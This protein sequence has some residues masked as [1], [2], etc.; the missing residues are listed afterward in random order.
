MNEGLRKRFLKVTERFAKYRTWLRNAP[1]TSAFSNIANDLGLLAKC[2]SYRN[3]NIIAG[4][5]LK[6]VEWLRAQSWDFDSARDVISY[7][8]DIIESSE[9]D[10]LNVLP[11]S[12]TSVRIMN[13]HKAKGLEAPFVFLANTYGRNDNRK[14]HFHVDRSG[15]VTRGYLAITKPKGK[16]GHTRPIAT[17]A[18]WDQFQAEEK[19]FG[20]GEDD[21]LLY[22]A[23]TRA[24]CKLVVSIASGRGERSSFWK[25]LHDHL[26]SMS[27]LNVSNPINLNYQTSVAAPSMALAELNTQ[28]EASWSALRTPSYAVVA[29]KSVAMKQSKKRPTWRASGEYGAA[30]GSAIHNLLEIKMKQPACELKSF[31]RQ[32]AEQFDLGANRVEELVASVNSVAESDIW[33]RAKRSS[34]IYTEIP[35]ES[36]DSSSAVP[37]VTRGVIDL[38]FQESDGWIIVDYKT[39]DISDAD[40]ENATEFYSPQLKTYGEFWQNITNQ[41]VAELGLYF[42][43]PDRYKVC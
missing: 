40:L 33:A 5:F 25:P 31:A 26:C 35:F 16:H 36:L 20:I 41:P 30:W 43:K 42:T 13:V 8:E 39:D 12:G 27:E 34:K 17:P 38:C 3:G 1:F 28:I 32:N 29:A 19:E 9:T 7:L 23:S 2:S 21:R 11:Q 10:S 18:N 4:G 6:A 15:D 37:T 14:P 22:V 24:A